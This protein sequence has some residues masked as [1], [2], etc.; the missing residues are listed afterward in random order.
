MPYYICNKNADD[1]GRHEV[2]TT[3]CNHLPLPQNQ[4]DLGFHSDCSSAIN[5]VKTWNP[6]GFTFDGCYYC[7][8]SCHKG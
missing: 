4:I 3:S 1:K 6:T 7:C 5:K 2:H 8:P